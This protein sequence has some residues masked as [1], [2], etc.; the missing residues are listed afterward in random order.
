MWTE[1]SEFWTFTGLALKGKYKLTY[2]LDDL[3]QEH[4][5]GHILLEVLDE[6]FVAGFGKVMIGPICVDLQKKAQ[7][8][9]QQSGQIPLQG[10]MQLLGPIFRCHSHCPAGAGKLV[11]SRAAR[12]ISIQCIVLA[13][14][15]ASRNGP[16][17]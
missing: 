10:Q 4:T 2:N 14:H 11:Y 3:G 12:A 9:L 6:A 15:S 8:Q 16:V 1:T 17:Y 13:R 5:I 7:R